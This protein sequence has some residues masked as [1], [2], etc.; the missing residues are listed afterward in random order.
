MGGAAIGQQFLSAGLVDELVVHLVPVL[1]QAGRRMFDHLDADPV[2]DAGFSGRVSGAERD[3]WRCARG[4]R[5]SELAR[6]A[7]QPRTRARVASAGRSP[8]RRLY[9]CARGRNISLISASRCSMVSPS[10]RRRY[11]AWRS[12][13]GGSSAWRSSRHRGGGGTTAGD[14]SVIAAMPA[15]VPA[16]LSIL[17]QSFCGGRENA[18]LADPAGVER[19]DDGEQRVRRRRTA[20]NQA[21]V[22]SGHRSRARWRSGAARG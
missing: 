19:A 16:L 4:Q 10:A 15:R 7:T 6:A 5:S 3:P 14:R 22:A 9:G 18:A 17:Q 20:I 21:G 11:S 2:D 1:L 13:R 12:S 8:A